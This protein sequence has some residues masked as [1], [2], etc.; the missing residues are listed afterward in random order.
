MTI[1]EY[2]EIRKFIENASIVPVSQVLRDM[3][4]MLEYWENS[5]QKFKMDCDIIYSV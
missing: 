4:D 3:F 5:P 1:D 2:F